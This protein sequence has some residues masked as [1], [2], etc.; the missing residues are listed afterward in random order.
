MICCINKDWIKTLL[1][2]GSFVQTSYRVLAQGPN[3]LPPVAHSFI[4]VAHRG[5]HTQAP[6]NTLAAFQHAIDDGADFVEIDLRTTRDGQLVIMHDA[7]IDRMTKGTGKIN[8]MTFDSL[9]RWVVIEKTHP[10]WGT[11]EIPNLRQVLAL[12]KDRINIYLDFKQA[13]ATETYRQILEFGMEKQI[14]VYINEK[15]Q[16]FAWRKTAPQ[17]PLMISLPENIKDTEGLLQEVKATGADVLDGNEDQYTAD[18]ISAAAGLH[19]PVIP[20]I[21]NSSDDLV[22]WSRA[23]AKGLQGLQTNRPKALIEYVNKLKKSRTTIVSINN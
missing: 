6:E 5:D 17:M 7:T 19:C 11:F 3:P 8:S 23:L 1:L 14:L 4:V 15:A 20:D 12:C 10:D 21:Q 22:S 2:F 9:K 18:M 16:F 13:D